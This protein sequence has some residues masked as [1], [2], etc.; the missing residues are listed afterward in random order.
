MAI[1]ARITSENLSGK[2]ATV[3]FT[4]YTGETSGT[5]V[6]LGSKT[7]PFNN[8][9]T[10]PYGVYSLYLAEYDYTYTLT[11]PEPIG[12]TQ[13]FVYVDR[14]VESDN[15]GAATLNFNDFTAEV[16]DLGILAS[17]WENYDIY[18]INESGFM[19]YFR[20]ENNRD[21]RLV[22]F[23]D[24]SN[25]EIA[26]YSGTTDSFD[27]DELEGKW[28]YAEFE[29]EG[30]LKYFDGTS[31]Y[32]YN[33]DNTTHWIDIENDWDSTT[34]D[35]TFI[36]KK[37]E[38]GQWN[39][40]GN[41]ES[42]IVNPED[43]TTTLFKTWT[44]GTYVRH[45]MNTS[46]NFIVVE[47][48][49]QGSS[50]SIYTNLEIFDTS[51]TVLET[52]SLT[53][54]T[55]NNYYLEFH[56]TN[57]FTVVYY[58]NDE[59]VD[60]KIINYNGNTETLIET[61]HARGIEY[62]AMTILGT[63]DSGP[64]WGNMNNGGVVIILHNVSG[65][66]SVGTMVTYCDIIYMFDNQSSFSTYTFANDEPKSFNTWAQL[67]DIYRTPVNNGDDILSFLTIM[68]G[69]TRIESMDV[70]ISG[71]TQVN[72]TPL[73]NRTIV[74]IF[75]NDAN[76]VTYKYINAT[77]VVTDTV[78]ESLASSYSAQVNSEGE[79][80]YLSIATLTNGNVGFY[81]YSGSTEMIS[82]DYYLIR[83]DIYSYSS[84]NNEVPDVI[85]LIADGG[86]SGRTLTSTGISNEISFPI[87]A[88]DAPFSV[89]MGK[90]KFML[91]Y[92]DTTNNN[93]VKINLYDYNGTLL[94]S[95]SV[96]YFTNVSNS[97]GVKDRFVV[98]FY[99]GEADTRILYLV[100]EDVI[101]SV[102]LDSYDGEST[103]NDFIWY[104]D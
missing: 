44:D 99:N 10:H 5:T 40:D 88:E 18:P 57:K 60:Y 58:G 30:V 67:G 16:I 84:E 9:N 94:N 7:I 47:T 35:G 37:W 4:P 17:D 28:T 93:Y 86:V 51:G 100:S 22:I 76:N 38:R 34:S 65:Y 104:N 87:I 64:S 15:Y 72:F 32:T 12:G 26:R 82:T 11:I 61:S 53:G 41:G 73:N 24:S 59:T 77:G 97:W 48:Q 80:A 75:S 45:K 62:G 70:P 52:V 63:D 55:Y 2:T 95:E 56:G 6:N 21:E 42:Y 89:N 50:G 1:G 69:S 19:Y 3:T 79:V 85:L 101:T 102:E 39:Y 36:I 27:R 91:L 43:G 74:Q 96:T 31:V 92:Q 81:V 78:S 20:G 90:D 46:A 98:E 25:T 8:I 13:I 103:L 14:M 33:W 68:S 66:S 29:D 54:N 71:I 83:E 23:T 49:T